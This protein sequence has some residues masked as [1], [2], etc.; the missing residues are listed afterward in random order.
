MIKTTAIA[1]LLLFPRSAIAD[2]LSTPVSQR[3]SDEEK[4][5]F[6]FSTTIAFH[7]AIGVGLNIHEERDGRGQRTVSMA[8]PSD[9]LLDQ[10]GASSEHHETVIEEFTQQALAWEANWR[11]L[12]ETYWAHA[13]GSEATPYTV[14]EGRDLWERELECQSYFESLARINGESV[15]SASQKF[16]AKVPN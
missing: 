2:T 5:R 11:S 16:I 6:C 14:Q 8:S 1:L 10:V 7:F 9:W 12:G 4:I 15:Y 3:A 13:I